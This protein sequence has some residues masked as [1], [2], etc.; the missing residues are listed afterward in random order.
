MGYIA[1]TEY[2]FCPSSNLTLPPIGFSIKRPRS[3]EHATASPIISLSLECVSAH[4]EGEDAFAPYNGSH[5]F[6]ELGAFIYT[7]PFIYFNSHNSPLKY[8]LSFI[9]FYQGKL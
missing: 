5:T 9:F 4:H 8:K 3:A 1:V 2:C 7:V 6:S